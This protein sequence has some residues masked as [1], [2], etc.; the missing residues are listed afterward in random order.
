VNNYF[1]P[2]SLGVLLLGFTAFLSGMNSENTQK[3]DPLAPYFCLCEKLA[4]PMEGA[5]IK[6]NGTEGKPGGKQSIKRIKNRNSLLSNELKKLTSLIEQVREAFKSGILPDPLCS[7]TSCQIRV[8]LLLSM[9]KRY[10][11]GKIEFNNI[12]AEDRIF[13]ARAYLLHRS[14]I[15]LETPETKLES[16]Q[17]KEPY[18]ET[19]D[20]KKF[21]SLAEKNTTIFECKRL[22]GQNALFFLQT[23]L[24][25]V[26]KNTSIPTFGLDTGMGLS[27][28]PCYL[29]VLAL[30]KFCKETNTPIVI[31]CSTEDFSQPFG[32]P[33]EKNFL[34]EEPNTILC[35]IDEQKYP[36][37][38]FNAAEDKTVV[39]PEQ[40]VCII[41][42]YSAKSSVLQELC[43]KNSLEKL[44]DI[45]L[46]AAAMHYQV[47][48]KYKELYCEKKLPELTTLLSKEKGECS[49]ELAEKYTN[50]LKAADEFKQ[51]FSVN[52][53]MPSVY[54]RIKQYEVPLFVKTSNQ[55]NSGNKNKCI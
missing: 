49:N 54:K 15:L 43:T 30:F 29:S 11:V 19:I 51:I 26:L 28:T 5:P 27:T 46:A 1:L 37:F 20:D 21:L 55:S 4:V 48:G 9:F 50:S 24:T 34:K 7:D 35:K 44:E 3:L 38:V 33:Q 45:I 52:H 13:L 47:G 16:S 18:S 17:K 25:N 39:S 42:G 22:V 31:R 10:V 2:K 40:P 8:P 32:L 53:I 12:P 14:K 6:C 41:D 36:I 23:K